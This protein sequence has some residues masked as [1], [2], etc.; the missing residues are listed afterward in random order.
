MKCQEM[1]SLNTSV[2]HE[3]DFSTWLVFMS[4]LPGLWSALSITYNE[5][6]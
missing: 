6:D 1:K 2:N 5:Q 3:W 4:S